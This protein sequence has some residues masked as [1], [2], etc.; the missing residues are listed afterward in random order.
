M[1]LSRSLA[2]LTLAILLPGC[3]TTRSLF[4]LTRD[5]AAGVY[6]ATAHQIQLADH[7]GAAF[8]ASLSSSKKEELKTAG[9]RYLAVRTSDPTPEQWKQIRRDM[10]KP[11][12]KYQTAKSA[13]SKIY[14]VMIWD[15]QTRE[16]VGTDC[17]ATLSL[18]TPGDVVRFDTHTAQY[19]G[20]P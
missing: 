5:F 15:T 19:V 7:R 13:P 1:K 2:V 11:G 9:T 16:I 12:G 6:Q 14:C 8:F 10:Q 18:P 3:E 4:T 17:Y 20:T